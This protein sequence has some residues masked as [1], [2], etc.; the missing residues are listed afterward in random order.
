MRPVEPARLHATLPTREN[1]SAARR[2]S[3][4]PPT[5]DLVDFGDQLLLALPQLSQVHA[6]GLGEDEG[7]GLLPG[8]ILGALV[9]LAVLQAISLAWL[10]IISLQRLD[11]TALPLVWGRRQP[12]V[13][14]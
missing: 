4:P 8:S 5:R 14:H 6:G 11:G 12:G 1:L 13:L 10:V 9:W 3:P 7:S 2:H